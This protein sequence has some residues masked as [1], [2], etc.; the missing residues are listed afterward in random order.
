[1]NT[2]QYHMNYIRENQ[3]QT[4]NTKMKE[5]PQTK[6]VSPIVHLQGWEGGERADDANT[7]GSWVQYLF[8]ILYNS[9]SLQ[10]W[11]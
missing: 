10:K 2:S 3:E 9:D 4:S 6:E 8:L 1:M 7:E 11:L 5:P